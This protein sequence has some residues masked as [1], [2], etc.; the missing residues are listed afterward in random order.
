MHTQ[1]RNRRVL[2][3][4]DEPLMRWSVSETLSDHGFQVVETGDAQAA[5]SA[6]RD[7][8]QGFDVVVLDLNLPD[9]HDLSLLQL[10]HTMAPSAQ[11][12][13]MTA[14]ATPDVVRDALAAGAFDVV[15]KPFEIED[16]ARVVGR[17]MA[18]GAQRGVTIPY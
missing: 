12:V 2:V 8:T 6:V 1:G 15:N 13:L 14:Y 10:I 18:A 9:S 11:L 3:V 7:A 5:R 4:D 16:L 17:A